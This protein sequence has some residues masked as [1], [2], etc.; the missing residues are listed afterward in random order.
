[1]RRHADAPLS[2]RPLDII[3]ASVLDTVRDADRSEAERVAALSQLRDVD[4]LAVLR[5]LVPLL[6]EPLDWLGR[7]IAALLARAGGAVQIG[8]DAHGMLAASPTALSSLVSDVD[9]SLLCP[10]L[11][12]VVRIDDA[13]LL[14]PR[15]A[16]IPPW[17]HRSDDGIA[18]LRRLDRPALITLGAGHVQLRIGSHA[19]DDVVVPATMAEP[20]HTRLTLRRGT[21][22]VMPTYKSQ[23][24][25]TYV[26]GVRPLSPVTLRVGGRISLDEQPILELLALAPV[27][28]T[29][30][31]GDEGEAGEPEVG[32][33]VVEPSQAGHAMALPHRRLG[34]VSYAEP[35]ARVIDAGED[36]VVGRVGIRADGGLY[37]AGVGRA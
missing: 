12:P 5:A 1:V 17:L 21:C 9:G 13:G 20:H 15:L 27:L 31:G 34:V 4:D 23:R 16:A 10:A 35:I 25:F 14:Q 7:E 26:D 3:R 18:W 11:G 24:S 19:S 6:N 32:H 36:A 2:A 28:A 37:R 22:I 33:I 29:H 30:H 8:V